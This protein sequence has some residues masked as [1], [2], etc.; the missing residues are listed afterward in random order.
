MKTL[1]AAT[2]FTLLA[3]C[4]GMGTSSGSSTY[5]NAD[6]GSGGVN[7]ERI[8]HSYIGGR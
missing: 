2:V 6:S 1:I 5:G 4:S 7:D 3:G 8:F